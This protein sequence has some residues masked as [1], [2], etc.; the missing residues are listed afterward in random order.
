MSVRAVLDFL[1][2]M[3]CAG[4]GSFGGALC[5]GCF[6]AF[7]AAPLVHRVRC[8][9]APPIDA[10]GAHA[11]VLRRAVIE[12]KYHHR[13]QIGL[14]LGEL[15][16]SKLARRFDVIVPVPLHAQRFALRGFNQAACIATGIHS[17]HPHARVVRGALER[18]R[19]TGAQSKLRLADRASN[20]AG[21]FAPGPGWTKI[22]GAAV[23]LVDDVAT[24]GATLRACAELIGRHARSVSAACIAIRL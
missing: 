7:A 22:A 16:G 5:D 13:A 12:L 19:N 15:L 8:G 11:G 3:R 18:A 4:C 2:P 6:N 1:A 14:R 24:T 21:A 10:L 9:A 17:H 20:I 23:L